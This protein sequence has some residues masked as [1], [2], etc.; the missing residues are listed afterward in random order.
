MP[1]V[2]HSKELEKLNKR[3]E[4]KKTTEAAGGKPKRIILEPVQNG[5]HMVTHEYEHDYNSMK[6]GKKDQVFHVKNHSALK[7]HMD[8]HCP[9]CGADV[10][11]PA[12]MK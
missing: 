11:E 3:D 10:E 5:G 7:K 9:D 6:P 2:V 12:V 8:K 1:A 4:G